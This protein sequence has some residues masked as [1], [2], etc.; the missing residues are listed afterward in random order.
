MYWVSQNKEFVH[1]EIRNGAT[2]SPQYRGC[3]VYVLLRVGNWI[4]KGAKHI[5]LYN[6]F[7]FPSSLD[8]KYIN[9]NIKDLYNRTSSVIHS[10]RYI[11][12]YK[13]EEV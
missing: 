2:Q 9:E 1:T 13:K 7:S 6:S 8:F 5:A 4:P 3:L 12:K 11:L 10:S